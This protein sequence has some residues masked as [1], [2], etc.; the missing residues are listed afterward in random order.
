MILWAAAAA[1]VV[2][3]LALL[4]RPLLRASPWLVWPWLGSARW[5]GFRQAM[6]LLADGRC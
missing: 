1:L 5:V 2:G 4:L 3:A 6:R